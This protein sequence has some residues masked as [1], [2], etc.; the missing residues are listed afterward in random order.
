MFAVLCTSLLPKFYPICLLQA[1]RKTVWLLINWLLS[2]PT[3]IYTI[4][5]TDYSKT[6]VKRPLKNRQNKDLHG[7]KIFQYCTCPAGRVTYYFHSSCKHMR[8]SFK[9]VCNKEHKG[10]ICNT[11][12][13]SYSSQSTHPV[14]ILQDEC[15]GKNYSS[16]LDF[17]CSYERT[18][19]IFVP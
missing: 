4:F 7:T 11:T 5:K 2:Q 18:S 14:L 19:G 1:G 10:V 17:T 12:S 15:F 9:N 8:L 6:C 3:W 13:L 16:F